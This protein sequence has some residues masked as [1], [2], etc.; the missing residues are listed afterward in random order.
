[1]TS[2]Q[3]VRRECNKQKSLMK[4]N[5]GRVLVRRCRSCYAL[6]DRVSVFRRKYSGIELN[7]CQ[8][9]DCPHDDIGQDKRLLRLRDDGLL[10]CLGCC[11]YKKEEV[12]INYIVIKCVS[13]LRVAAVFTVLAIIIATK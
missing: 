11:R 8:C 3:M 9:T 7:S 5:R 4:F 12:V 10:A 6:S 2:C 13:T 1:M